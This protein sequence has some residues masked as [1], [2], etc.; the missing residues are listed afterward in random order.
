M[1]AEQIKTSIR[2]SIQ[3]FNNGNLTERCIEFF[4]ILFMT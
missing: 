4:E 2:D 1:T 3:S